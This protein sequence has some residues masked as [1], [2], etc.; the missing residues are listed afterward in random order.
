MVYIDSNGNL[1]ERRSPWRIM[2]GPPQRIAQE[3][4]R[5]RTTYTE[6]QGVRRPG[7]G[8]G[9]GANIRGCRDLGDATA[10]AGG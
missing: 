10:A 9:G 7:S 5:S 1:Q 4:N 3:Q 6:R 2:A 8:G